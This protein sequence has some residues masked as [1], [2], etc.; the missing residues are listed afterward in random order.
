MQHRKLG[1]LSKLYLKY[2][3]KSQYALYKTA[4]AERIFF[5]DVALKISN[6]SFDNE[7]GTSLTFKHSGNCGDIIYALPAIYELSKNG[8]ASILLHI[9]QKGTYSA[10]HPLG[11][12]MLNQKVGDM[13]R[14]LLLYQ[15]QVETVETYNGEEVDYDLDAF[16]TLPILLDRGNI[17]RWYFW[18]Q[19]IS[20]SLSLPWLVAPKESSLINDYIVI[21]RSHRY[22][23]PIISYN[24]LSKYPKLLF[25]GV[26]EE[27]TDM[28][29]SIPNLEFKKVNDFLE[30]ATIIN[31]CKLF[32]GN[33][34]F[35]F[36]I[37]EGLKVNRLLE[38][39]YKAPNVSPEGN[40][41]HDFMFQPQFEKLTA[42]LYNTRK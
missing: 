15:P 28:L 25:I 42:L 2:T 17:S 12:L 23:N 18:V 6:L 1:T 30:M 35:P 4:E 38:V 33:Q 36:A 41:A 13:I 9:N 29:K 31:N 3:N 20:H 16:R 7:L 19:G 11:D 5:Q 39:Y 34:S 24:F 32:I 27:Y 21:A 10:F 22:R 37:A 14:P 26:E 8:K 40:G